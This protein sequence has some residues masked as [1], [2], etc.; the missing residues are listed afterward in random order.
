MQARQRHARAR[1]ICELELEFELILILISDA[2]RVRIAHC[3][4]IMWHDNGNGIARACMICLFD[5]YGWILY[6]FALKNNGKNLIFL[7]QQ[8]LTI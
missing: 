6:A 1:A 7:S 8:N 5:G 3:I 2:S 4:T